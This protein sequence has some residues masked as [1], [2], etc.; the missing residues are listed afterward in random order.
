MFR[1]GNGDPLNT[2]HMNTIGISC[3]AFNFQMQSF[4]ENTVKG[5]FP[6]RLV[7]ATFAPESISIKKMLSR[8]GATFVHFTFLVYKFNDSAKA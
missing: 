2:K 5:L 8:N 3:V 7:P 6:D 1:M 4:T